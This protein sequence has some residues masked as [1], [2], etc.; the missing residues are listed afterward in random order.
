ME[1]SWIRHVLFSLIRALHFYAH[2]ETF[3]PEYVKICSELHGKLQAGLIPCGVQWLVTD[4]SE[5]WAGLYL[6]DNKLATIP[7]RI[8]RSIKKI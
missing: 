5:K 7:D 4:H 3:P 6:L 8:W 2:G 1:L